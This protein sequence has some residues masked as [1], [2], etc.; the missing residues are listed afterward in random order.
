MNKTICYILFI[1]SL[2]SCKPDL[3]YEIRGYT[4]KIIVEGF[5]ANGE[6][7]SVYLSLN[8]PLSKTVDTVTILENVIRTAK[9]TISDGETTEILTSRWDKKHFPPYVY[10]GTELKGVEGK[11]YYL[12]VDYGG[13][14]LH[15]QT[16]I[17][18]ATNI[19]KFNMIPVAGNDSMRLL[20]M[21]FD[22]DAAKKNAY[23]VFTKKMKDGFFTQTPIVYNSEF[24][25]SGTN[26][27]NIS[28]KPDTKDPSSSEGSYFAIGD[29]VQVKLC[30]ID[31][32]ATQF[33]KALTIFSA[34]GIGSNFF[35]GE[36]DALKSNISSPG[37]GIWYGNGTN[38]YQVVIQ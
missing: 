30:T 27:F 7:P 35:I 28:P 34:S 14:T 20:T 26:T 18:Y 22:I 5:I 15:S 25:L 1:L 16:T 9:V 12:T 29:T 33:F 8:I 36:K 17:P 24:A 31:S 4:Q 2:I 37:F 11:T 10:R 38:S 32:V 19:L 23:R 6:F 13:Y 3:N 21:T